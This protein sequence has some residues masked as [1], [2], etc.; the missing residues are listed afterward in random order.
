MKKLLSLSSFAALSLLAQVAHADFNAELSGVALK[1]DDVKLYAIGGSYYF[2]N[3]STRNG[4]LAE[5]S[6]LDKQSAVSAVVSRF[7]GDDDNVNA[8]LLGGTYVV[9]GSG[10][11][12]NASVAHVNGY[13]ADTYTFG[14]GYYLSRDWAVSIDSDFDEDMN[15]QGLTLGSKKLFGLGGENFVSLEGSYNNPD[16]GDDS[17]AVA[18]DFYL[19]RHLSV[20]LGYEWSDS[21]SDGITSVRSQWFIN[22]RAAIN[23]E[24][25]YTDNNGNSD[26]SYLLGATLRF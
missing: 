9:Q 20:G 24:I 14:G 17:F 23:G 12:L 22:E 19:N 4:P 2:N 13:S 26:T 6:F 8:W 5:A 21:F 18:S 1:D 7:D 16:E 25:A 15:Y 10:L 3:V 11:Y